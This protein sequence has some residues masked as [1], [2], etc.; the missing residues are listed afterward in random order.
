M[1]FL[2]WPG[3]PLSFL[4]SLWNLIL[5]IFPYCCLQV[6]SW[7]VNTCPGGGSSVLKELS[8]SRLARSATRSLRPSA[9]HMTWTWSW[10][11]APCLV[12]WLIDTSVKELILRGCRKS[13]SGIAWMHILIV[14]PAPLCPV[15]V[16]GSLYEVRFFLELFSGGFFPP[17]DLSLL[18]Y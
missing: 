3:L 12:S 7:A 18:S 9:A 14:V 17:E 4:D 2:V 13:P 16:A 15:G 11:V 5:W 1:S 8:H 10:S 6:V